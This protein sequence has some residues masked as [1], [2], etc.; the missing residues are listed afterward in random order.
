MPSEMTYNMF[1]GTPPTLYM[2]MLYVSFG[3]SNVN[4]TV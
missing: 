2:L 3:T 1:C 4:G